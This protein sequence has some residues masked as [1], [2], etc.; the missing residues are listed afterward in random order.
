MEF[1]YRQRKKVLMLGCFCKIRSWYPS[2]RC[3]QQNNGKSWER[4]NHVHGKRWLMMVS[5]TLWSRL[6]GLKTAVHGRYFQEPFFWKLRFAFKFFAR[7]YLIK[8]YIYHNITLIWRSQV[9]RKIAVQIRWWCHK[10]LGAIEWIRGRGKADE[11]FSFFVLHGL[12]SSRVIVYWLEIITVRK[13]NQ[14]INTWV[15]AEYQGS[16]AI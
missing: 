11:G 14:F 12:E 9:N 5:R 8:N 16:C 7:C 6:L 4:K 2:N 13:L 10:S 1:V 15:I 3:H